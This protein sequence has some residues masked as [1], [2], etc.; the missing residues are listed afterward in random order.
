MSAEEVFGAGVK[1][2]LS[3]TTSGATQSIVIYFIKSVVFSSEFRPIKLIL[4]FRFPIIWI[5]N[6]KKS[7]LGHIPLYST[8]NQYLLSV[9]VQVRSFGL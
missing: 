8:H 7:F 6:D 1:H 9:L 4:F 2:S 3:D 5:L